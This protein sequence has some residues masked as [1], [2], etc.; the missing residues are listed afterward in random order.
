MVPNITHGS[1]FQGLLRYLLVNKS[2]GEPRPNA[3]LIGGSLTGQTVGEL[4]AEFGLVRRLR[5]QAEKVVMHHSLSYAPGENPSDEQINRDAARYLEHMGLAEHPHAIVVHRDKGCIHPHIVISKI[6]ADGS[7]FD[8]KMD[9]AHSQI[10]AGLV[11]REFGLVE[12][13][14]L[15][16]QKYIDEAW[17]KI[18]QERPELRRAKPAPRLADMSEKGVAAE[19]KRRLSTIPA[20]LTLPEWVQAAEWEGLQL[21]P[22]ISGEGISGWNVQLRGTDTPHM[23]LSKTGVVWKKLQESGK[24]HFDPAQ[25]LDFAKHLKEIPFAKPASTDPATPLT[26]T[27]ESYP[28][29][30]ISLNW[31]WQAKPIPSPEQQDLVASQ[32]VSRPRP[33]TRRPGLRAPKLAEVRR[34]QEGPTPR[35][36]LGAGRSPGA[37]VATPVPGN[38]GS[39]RRLDSEERTPDPTGFGELLDRRLP[40]LRPRPWAVAPDAESA[41]GSGSSP[42][43]H[44][45]GPEA[46]GPAA[47]GVLQRSP[48]GRVQALPGGRGSSSTGS[49]GVGLCS[50]RRGLAH[51][52]AEVARVALAPF[53]LMAEKIAAA[54]K[55]RRPAVPKLSQA[56]AVKLALS[57]PVLELMPK[58]KAN[59]PTT[60]PWLMERDRRDK[61][62]EE[63]AER[64]RLEREQKEA[65]ERA[66]KTPRR[67]QEP[68]QPDPGPDTPDDSPRIKRGKP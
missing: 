64:K 51:V 29:D 25:H 21:Q 33:R 50:D 62:I 35:P 34:H 15:A 18:V 40:V 58:R 57:S 38:V 32:V 53:K 31:D 3:H 60:V 12:V 23:K 16:K 26:R 9:Y 48:V 13:P 39:L 17:A 66:A 5:S 6:G 56:Q 20:G 67:V 68:P 19:I 44:D 59:E 27:P 54:V 7:W 52:V 1:G 36:R 65:L 49:G 61:L 41:P 8:A 11:E 22:N 10:A 55:L 30:P 4:S 46:A 24:V 45:H 14:R 2:T 28:R 37:N 42:R 43:L 63:A 47:L